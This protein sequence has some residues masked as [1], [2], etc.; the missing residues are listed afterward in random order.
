[1]NVKDGAELT[2]N[3]QFICNIYKW[4][5]KAGSKQISDI[6]KRQV[7]VMFIPDLMIGRWL[8]GLTNHNKAGQT[9]C[10]L[11]S[12]PPDVFVCVKSPAHTPFTP[13][14]AKRVGG[15]ENDT[16]KACDPIKVHLCSD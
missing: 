9:R 10:T 13:S 6:F 14:E 3:L 7:S 5:P 2:V 15:A 12:E 8:Q 1:M 11:S 4:C 16:V